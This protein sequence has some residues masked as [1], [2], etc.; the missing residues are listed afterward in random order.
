MA[1]TI[2]VVFDQLSRIFRHL[3][4]GALVIGLASIAHPKWFDYINFSNS[5]HMTILA[6][7]AIVVGNLWYVLHR[8][9]I[10]Q[11]I[12]Y[13]LYVKRNSKIKGYITWLSAYLDKSFKFAKGNPELKNHLHFRS[14][15]IILLFIFC[16]SLI[17]FSFWNDECTFFDKHSTLIIW[18][19]LVLLFASVLQYIISNT[20]DLQIVEHG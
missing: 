19:S 14:A 13:L 6:L 17:L 8:Y 5:W 15:Q 9:T 4:P 11:L 12:D 18:I 3:L 10:H 2:K 7:I 20:L 16:E 1:D